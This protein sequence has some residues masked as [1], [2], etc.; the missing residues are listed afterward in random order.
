MKL[1]FDTS[2]LVAALV[3]DHPHHDVARPW[4][5]R[6]GHARMEGALCAHS[7]AELYSVL[8]AMPLRP[9]PSTDEVLQLLVESVLPRMRVIE[10]GQADYQRALELCARRR[11]RS[12]AI[13]DALI[14]V[15]ARKAKARHLVTLNPNDFERFS[16]DAAAWIVDPR[17]TKPR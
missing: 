5:T 14:E 16:E 2:T 17:T 13:F 1:F 8:S 15:A 11:L 6:L 7:L 3:A 4:V 12:G 10:L 9:R